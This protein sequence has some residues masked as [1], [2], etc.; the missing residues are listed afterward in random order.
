MIDDFTIEQ[1][2]KDREI[3]LLKIKNLEHGVIQAE[4]MIRESRM[5]IR[6]LTFLRRKIAESNQD[7]ECLSLILQNFS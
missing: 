5:N 2:K 4:E 7:L 3:L 1:C 6:A